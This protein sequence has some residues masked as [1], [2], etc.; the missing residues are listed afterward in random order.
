MPRL[1]VTGVTT[2]GPLAPLTERM[3]RDGRGIGLGEKRYP[4]RPAQSP[5]D[6]LVSLIPVHNSKLRETNL[7]RR[8][9]H[10]ELILAENFKE[11]TGQ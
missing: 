6:E 1:N 2:I 7:I 9:E 3:A 11:R 4:S 10:L 5:R 8:L